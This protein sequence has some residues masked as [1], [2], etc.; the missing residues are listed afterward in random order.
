MGKLCT[1][2][3]TG[4]PCIFGYKGKSQQCRPGGPVTFTNGFYSYRK[5]NVL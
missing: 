5:M 2:L 1:G 3:V 4:T